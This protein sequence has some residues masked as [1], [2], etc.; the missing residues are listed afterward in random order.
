MLIPTRESSSSPAKR[1]HHF[2]KHDSAQDPTSPPHRNNDYF[3]PASEAPPLFETLG[4]SLHTTEAGHRCL[5]TAKHLLEVHP[6]LN[7]APEL[8][9]FRWY[10][11]GLG[12][13]H[14]FHTEPLERIGISR[15][16]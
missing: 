1:P 14:A 3:Y 12:S 13:F 11:R 10:G 6:S 2:L 9:P 4:G 16:W 8:T 15:T 5:E 7:E